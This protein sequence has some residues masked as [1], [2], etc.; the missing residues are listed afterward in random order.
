MNSVA[1][2]CSRVFI[3]GFPA[4]SAISIPALIAFKYCISKASV[5][6]TGGFLAA[7]ASLIITGTPSFVISCITMPLFASL[8]R[9]RVCSASVN[10]PCDTSV[11]ASLRYCPKSSGAIVGLFGVDCKNSWIT[12]IVDSLSD[13]NLS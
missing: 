11:T 8:K 5:S 13:L 4:I 7:L 2:L 9:S 3:A 10:F 12:P 6:R 1:S